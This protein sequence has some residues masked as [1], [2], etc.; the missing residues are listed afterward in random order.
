MRG[1]YECFVKTLELLTLKPQSNSHVHLY[2]LSFF[3]SETG[4]KSSIRV[5]AFTHPNF[6][7]S[8]QFFFLFPH[9]N[10]PLQAHLLEKTQT[11]NFS[12]CSH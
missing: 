12:E 9:L 7:L 11:R 2:V 6:P 10:V 5:S 1:Q 3:P 8:S 4:Q